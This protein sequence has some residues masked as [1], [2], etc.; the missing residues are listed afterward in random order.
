MV[1]GLWAPPGLPLG[2]ENYASL[3]AFCEICIFLKKLKNMNISEIVM[4]SGQWSPPGARLGAPENA[5]T[6]LFS[7]LS[8]YL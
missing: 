5:R 8:C 6:L 2:G 4:V 3:P 1:S 7:A